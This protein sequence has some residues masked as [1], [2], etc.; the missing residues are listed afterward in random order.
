MTH[1]QTTNFTDNITYVLKR[2]HNLTFGYLFRKLAAEQPDVSERARIVQLQRPAT[3]ELNQGQ[4]VPGTGFDFADFLLGL[5]QS[6]SLRFGSDDNYFRGWATA[7][8]RRTIIASRAGLSINFGLRYEYFAPYTELYGHLANLDLQ[9]GFTAAQVVT[10]ATASANSDCRP[11]W[12]GPRRPI[13]RRASA[14]PGGRRR[15]TAS[16]F[17]GGYSIFYSGSPYA[18]DRGADGVAAAVRENGVDQH[19]PRRSADA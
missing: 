19:Q 6:S 15:R 17:R 12:C 7:R 11:A 5:P 18:H 4:P 10:P 2:K 9:P 8:S 13:F 14:S 3:S 1:N 16:M